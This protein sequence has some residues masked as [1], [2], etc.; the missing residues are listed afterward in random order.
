MARQKMY[1]RYEIPTNVVNIVKAICVDYERR[2]QLLR[3]DSA[4]DPDVRAELL[5]LNVALESALD[6]V[7]IGIRKIILGDIQNNR[8]Y[9]H[10]RSA[11]FLAKNTYYSRKRKLIYDIAKNMNLI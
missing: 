2:K 1:F 5:S 11:A 4:L 8:G 7:E 6:N 3:N 9:D 10:S